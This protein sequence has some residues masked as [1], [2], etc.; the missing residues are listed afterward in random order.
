MERLC[1]FTS[2]FHVFSM[3]HNDDEVVLLS[4]LGVPSGQEFYLLHL[5]IPLSWHSVRNAADVCC[6]LD[7]LLNKV[8]KSEKE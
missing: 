1:G 2:S 6:L 7:Q 3:V 8:A 5:H 4:V